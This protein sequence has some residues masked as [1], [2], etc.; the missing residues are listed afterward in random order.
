MLKSN[1]SLRATQQF[2]LLHSRFNPMTGPWRA[3]ACLRGQDGRG[4]QGIHRQSGTALVFFSGPP[5]AIVQP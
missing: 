3:Q 2:G 1:P 5:S 4:H